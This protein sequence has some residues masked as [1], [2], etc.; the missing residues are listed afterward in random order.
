[1][2]LIVVSKE[3]LTRFGCPHCGG[4]T[5]DDFLSFG[6]CS[7]ICCD[8]CGHQCA[9]VKNSCDELVSVRSGTDIQNL[10][11]QHPYKRQN[12]RMIAAPLFVIPKY[13]PCAFRPK[14]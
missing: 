8:A 7:I 10:I 11:G 5:E 12:D 3:E 13:F 4:A 14:A 2:E 9:T 1:M 6:S